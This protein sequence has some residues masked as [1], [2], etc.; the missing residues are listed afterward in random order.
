MRA[1]MQLRVEEVQSS[2]D[3]TPVR[4]S[5][6]F[7]SG[8]LQTTEFFERGVNWPSESTE[9]GQKFPFHL[10]ETNSGRVGVAIYAERLAEYLGAAGADPLDINHS[11]AV[12]V[13]YV[14]SVNATRPKIPSDMTDTCVILR[15]SKDFTMFP[16]GFSLVTGMRLYLANDVNVVPKGTDA[17]GNE[18]FPPIS[19]FAPEKR[20]GL[21]DHGIMIDFKGQLVHLG[22]DAAA[23]ARLLDLKSGKEETVIPENIQA[24]LFGITNIDQLPPITQMSWLVVIEEVF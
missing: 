15:G 16:A 11:L 4:I 22:K 18:V 21:R 1:A 10:E 3:Q 17:A 23:P 6:T 14:D 13:N 2:L 24:N 7:L 20:F 19:L 5:F 12:N 8:G 9:E